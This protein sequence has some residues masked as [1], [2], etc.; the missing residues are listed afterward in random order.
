[1]NES[2]SPCVAE[3]RGTRQRIT[4]LQDQLRDASEA[5]GL[6]VDVGAPQARIERAGARM[7]A[8]A[9]DLRAL[10]VIG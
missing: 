2:L 8:A 5:W 9:A 10:G 3:V 6:L 1:M 7:D 4:E